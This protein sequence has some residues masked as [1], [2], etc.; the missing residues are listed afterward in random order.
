MIS[1]IALQVVDGPASPHPAVLQ[2]GLFSLQQ[3]VVVGLAVMLSRSFAAY[4][5]YMLCRFSG[6]N[7]FETAGASPSTPQDRASATAR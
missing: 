7:T 4:R 6:C 1:V 2:A 5:Q 3:E